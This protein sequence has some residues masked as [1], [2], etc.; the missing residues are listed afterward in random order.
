MM[1]R[2]GGITSVQFSRSVVS[3]SLRSHGPQHARLPC[4]SPTPRAYS[5]LCPSSWWSHRA[6]S[7]SVVPFSSHPQSF[8]ISGSFQM[9]QL[10]ASGGQRTGVSASPSV[11]PMNIQDWFPLIIYPWIAHTPGFFVFPIFNRTSLFLLSDDKWW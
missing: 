8:P 10:F 2:N 5:Y 1:A 7:S 4:P 11:L 6:I 3:D 9:S